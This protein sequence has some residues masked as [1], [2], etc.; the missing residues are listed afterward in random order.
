M[1]SHDEMPPAQ[2]DVEA[3]PKKPSS[4][5]I[6][7]L[8]LC[9]LLLAA[10]VTAFGIIGRNT[11]EATLAQ[12]TDN[13][14]TQT[15]AVTHATTETK[16]RVITL[17]GDIEAFYNAVLYARVPGYLK[18]WYK[19]IG[20]QVKAG[21]VLADI[22]T[23]ELDQQVDQARADLASA[24][25]DAALA[26][27]TARRWKA[28][29]KSNSVS[30]QTADEKSGD[31]VV[32]ATVVNARTASLQR[33]LE[34]ESFKHIVAPFAGVVTARRTDIGALINAG[35]GGGPALFDVADIHAMR[36]YV[37]VPQ[38]LSSAVQN[39]TEATLQ[40]PQYPG[41]IFTAKVVTSSNA[42]QTASRTVLVQL[43]ADNPD[44]ALLPGTFAQ[45]S[46]KLPPAS[47]VLQ[48][49]A[50]ALIFQAHGLQV[51]TVGAGGRVAVHDIQVGRDLGT[52][53]EVL[54]GIT[55]T[56]QVILSPP[57]TITAGQIVRVETAANT[58][59]PIAQA[60]AEE[61]Q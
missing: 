61:A 29:L 30:Q 54:S 48:L 3:P 27:L 51:A 1:T 17:P 60:Q 24:K 34:L 23:P 25:A 9:L 18:M 52:A 56:D 26:D 11:S 19:D 22:S 50:T 33:L 58:P 40:L 49:P 16:E 2:D 21:D 59:K 10:G 41:R 46:F 14:A 31:A 57:D 35:G 53:V 38:A 32:K 39:G 45:V 15:V 28:L 6:R 37:R 43:Q 20:A 13:Q 4:W 36:I 47:G 8:A 55:A 42:V 5:S 44:G 7:V 12:W